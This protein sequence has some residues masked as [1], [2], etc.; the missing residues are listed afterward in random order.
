MTLAVTALSVL[1]FLVAFQALGIV[2]KAREAIETSRQTARVMGDTTLDDDA[3][4]AAVQNA[5]KTLMIGFGG[6]VLRIVGILGAAYVPIFLAD[7][8]GIVPQDTTLGFMLRID[9]I[10]ASTVIVIAGV[11]LLARMRR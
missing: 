2:A 3:K 11:W 1:A 8:L 4:E 5:A 10:L 7:A 9:V 6:L